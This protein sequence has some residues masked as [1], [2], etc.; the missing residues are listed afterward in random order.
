ILHKPGRVHTAERS[1]VRRI[2]SL[3]AEV[4]VGAGVHPGQAIIRKCQTNG[5]FARYPAKLWDG[6]AIPDPNLRDLAAR[7]PTRRPYRIN[8][9]V[10]CIS[11][12][13]GHHRRSRI[14]VEPEGG[15]LGIVRMRRND[16]HAIGGRYA[17]PA[18]VQ[19]HVLLAPFESV[20]AHAHARFIWHALQQSTNVEK[21]RSMRTA[22]HML[23]IM[24]LIGANLDGGIGQ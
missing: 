16:Q 10:A 6:E 4:A 5:S 22:L 9:T 13:N 14:G 18:T 20:T 7:K 2:R 19:N 11:R 15:D 24:K 23:D 8:V 3:T 12:R 1:E 17:L 21:S